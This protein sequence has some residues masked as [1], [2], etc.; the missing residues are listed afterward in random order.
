MPHIRKNNSLNASSVLA[1]AFFA[2]LQLICAPLL[3]QSS[4]SDHAIT[5]PTRTTPTTRIRVGGG[6]S[7]HEVAHHEPADSAAASVMPKKKSL[8]GVV[9]EDQSA[10]LTFSG[11]V[12]GFYQWNVNRPSNH[13]TNFRGFD[14][15]HNSF[16][17]SNAVLDALWDNS[18]LEARIALQVGNT[19]S[20]YY[21]SEPGYSGTSSVNA[22]SSEL[23]RHLQ[24]AYVGYRAPI[25]RGL[26]IQAGLFLTPIGPETVP[27]NS[28][29]NWSRS[30]LFFGLPFYHTGVRATYALT[31]QWAL[32]L[33]TY[34]GWN[35]IGDNNNEKSVSAQAN[36]TP[37]TDLQLSFVYF[38]G[39]ERQPGGPEG[40]AWR[41]LYDGYANWHA[42]RRL[43]LMWHVDAGFEPNHF[44]TSSWAATAA[45]ARYEII[46]RLF[47]VGRGDI[48]YEHVASNNLG[49]ARAIFWPAKWVSSQ[50]L[51]LDYR[52]VD[53]IAFMLEYRHDQAQGNMFFGGSVIGDGSTVPF[54]VNRKSQDTLTVGATAW[55]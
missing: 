25:G 6:P 13:I 49:T 12:E 42:S 23:W 26:L 4:P 45:Y 41:H 19:P 8:E 20:S 47:V 38:S 44:G 37:N 10:F 15:R 27:V 54:V 40:R 53:H 31:D 7:A 18:F 29:W 48:F 52:P 43:W 30:N 34:N 32:T 55:F 28:N 14:N 24:K 2:G 35:S 9:L 17:I 22:T 50:T 21:L 3:A 33:G 16:T 51:T 5:E 36:Y 1:L 11:Y 46:D 39:V